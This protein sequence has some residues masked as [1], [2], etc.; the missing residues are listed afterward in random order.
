MAQSL[1][2]VRLS[3]H[4]KAVSMLI[5]QD[6]SLSIAGRL[7]IEKASLTLPTGFKTGF[8]GLNG[9]GKTSL[10]RAINGDIALEGGEIILP[11]QMRIGQVAQEAP[12]SDEPLIEIVLAADKERCQLLREAQTAQDATRIAEIHARLADIDA[13]SAPARA[14]TILSG[15]GFDEAAQHRP[16]SSLSGGWRMRVALACVLFSRPDLLLLDEPTNYLDLEGTIWLQDYI[17]HY[18][19]SVLMI[20]HDRELLNQTVTS[21]LHLSERKLTLWRGTYDQFQ[22]QRT[23]TMMLQQKQAVKQQAHRAHMQA[24]VDRFRAKATKARQAQSRLKALEKLAPVSVWQTEEVMPFRFAQADKPV[25]SP[26]IALSGGQVGYEADKPILSKLDLRIDHDDRIALLGA[27]G[28]GKSTFAKL[29]AG[30]LSI[31]QG[32]LTLAPGLKMAFFA[33]HQIDDL[34]PQ[35][36]AIEHL[37]RLLPQEPEARLR[38]RIAQMGLSTKKMLTPAQELS[39]GEKARL[40]MGLATY[41]S[42]H[43]L[44]LDEPTNHL[45]MDSREALT[46]ALNE[47]NGAVV[48]IAHDRHLI[49]AC[50]ERLWLVEGGTVMSFDGD[51]EDYQAHI[52]GRTPPSRH[53]RASPSNKTRDEQRRENAQKRAQLA[54]LRKQI[55]DIEAKMEKYQ[56]QIASLDLALSDS[57]LYV[58]NSQEATKKAQQRAQYQAELTAAESHWLTL[59]EQIEKALNQA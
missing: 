16:V 40:L 23:E 19:A 17:R 6:I 39:G 11:Q 30:R 33:Q 9:T 56:H 48:L 25:A 49:E 47:F 8:V 43:L 4:Y 51:M 18:P 22:R 26:I 32:T 45:D 14:A 37:R 53:Q 41:D 58:D 7:L 21:I 44:I 2:Q 36:N 20:S 5:L 59:S 34:R 31:Q 46:L 13:H 10:F 50:A 55:K 3:A 1:R 12:S 54:P 27:N 42:P 15:L 35:E 24:F 28:N 52:L 57:T 38:A 29:L